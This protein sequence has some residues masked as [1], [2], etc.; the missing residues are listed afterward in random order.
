LH[1]EEPRHLTDVRSRGGG[2]R[3]LAAHRTKPAPTLSTAQPRPLEGKILALI[4]GSEETAEA[5]AFRAAATALGA[6]VAWMRPSLGL[7]SSEEQVLAMGRVLGRLYDA[8]ECQGLDEGLA[9]RIRAA[10]GIPVFDRLAGEGELLLQA[11]LL[12]ALR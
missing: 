2:M 1:A 8:I 4:S 12:Q 5:R 7:E 9:E 10:A 3:S 6:R 11:R